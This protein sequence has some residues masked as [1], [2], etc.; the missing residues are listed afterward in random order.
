MGNEVK[1]R[2]NNW[3]DI[4]DARVLLDML[5]KSISIC[6]KYSLYN[7]DR[8]WKAIIQAVSHTLTGKCE[9]HL[10]KLIND[11]HNW[12]RGGENKHK[13]FFQELC[14]KIFKK[15][16]YENQK[17]AMRD[18]LPYQ[19]NDHRE[20]IEQLI[21]INEIL[22]NMCEGGS[23]FD[24]KYFHRHLIVA[25]LHEKARVE[26]IKQDGRNLWDEDKVLDLLEEIQDGIEAKMQIKHANRHYNNNNLKNNDDT[27]KHGNNG[28][29]KNWCR[30]K[31]NNH[32]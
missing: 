22:P 7:G 32:K 25:T 14:K 6:N 15:R 11:T 28:N 1:E 8:D 18:G 23:R 10:D 13:R 30:K 31:G 5:I 29:K 20:A 3:R 9:K 2:F 16:G 27:S 12:G 24:A 19:G 4:K 26:F 17:D 21:K